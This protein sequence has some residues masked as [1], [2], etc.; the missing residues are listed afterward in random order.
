MGEVCWGLFR[1]ALEDI[2]RMVAECQRIF[3]KGHPSLLRIAI[4]LR[5]SVV[6]TD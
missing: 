4:F 6:F 1:R 5:K 3:R 2:G